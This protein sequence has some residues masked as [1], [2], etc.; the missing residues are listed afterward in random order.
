MAYK[1]KRKKMINEELVIEGAGGRKDLRVPVSI[2]V[3]DCLAQFNRLRRI[4]GELQAEAEKDPSSETTAAKLGT[5]IVA[6][7]ELIFGSAGCKRLLEYYD[8]AY[9]EM[10]EDVS[11]FV[12]DVIIPQMNLAMA[13]RAERYRKIRGRT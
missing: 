3:D 11:P 2:T 7:F 1:I 4:L 9:T 13:E 8:N 10:L 12:V 6:F 5:V